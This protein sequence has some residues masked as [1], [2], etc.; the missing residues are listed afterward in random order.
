MIEN[1]RIYILTVYNAVRTTKTS[2]TKAKQKDKSSKAP[3][4]KGCAS[5]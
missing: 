5:Q 2:K 4:P 1:L 3:H